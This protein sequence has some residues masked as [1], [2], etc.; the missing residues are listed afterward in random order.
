M[1]ICNIIWNNDSY[2]EFISYLKSLEDIEYREFN[3]KIVNTKLDMIG[4]R[5]PILKSIS[6][7]ICKTNIEDYIKLVNNKYYEEVFIYG[8][9]L[10]NSNEDLIDKYIVDFLNRIDNWAICDSFCTSLKIIN[11]KM[12]KYFIYLCSLIDLDKEFQ[13]RFSIVCLM[14]Y[15]LCDRYIDRVLN[16][17]CNINSN[18]YYINMAISWLLSSAIIKYEDKIIDILKNKKLDKFIQNKTISK[19]CDSCKVSIDVKNSVKKY[20]IL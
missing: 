3:K 8:L 14:N 10:A 11:N 4:I 17:V 19:I 16:I 2:K 13:T 20:R 18:Y 1:D 15:Y 12:G 5:V 9:V 6:K 7:K